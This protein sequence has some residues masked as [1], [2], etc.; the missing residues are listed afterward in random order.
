MRNRVANSIFGLA[1]LFVFVIIT[2]ASTSAAINPQ[3]NFQGKITNPDGT[4]IVNGSY[5]IR[6]RLYTDPALDAANTCSA[7]TCKW[8]ESK[9]ITITDGIFQTALGSLT[10]L[11]GSVDFNTS[12]IYLGIKVG[13]DPE[14]APRVQFTA[15][16][17][18]FNSDKVGGFTAAQLVQLTPAGQQSGSINVSG[19]ITTASTLAV[20][21]SNAVTLGSST[22]VGAILFQDGTVNN[23]TVT[24]NVAALPTASYSLTLPTSAPALSQCLQSGASVAGQLAFGACGTLQQNYAASG[25]PALITTTN[26]K[27]LQV[28]LANTATAANFLVNVATGSTGKFAIQNNSTDVFLYSVAT[29]LSTNNNSLAVGSG[30]VNAAI[31]NATTGLNTGAASGTQ[32][33]DSTGN[34]VSI[35]NITTSGATTLSTTGATGVTIKPGSETAS[36]FQLQSAAAINFIAFNSVTST[37][38]FGPTSANASTVTIATGAAAQAVTIGSTNTTSSTA[39]QGGTTGAINLGSVGSSTLASTTAIAST[40]D[41]TGLQSV[42]IGSNAN[43]NNTVSIEA[44]NTGLIKIGDASTTAHTIRI[45]ASGLAAGTAQTVLVGSNTTTTASIVKLQAGNVTSVNGQAGVTVGGGFSTSDTNLVPLNLDSTITLTE[46][47]NTCT[48]SVNDGALYF[49]ANA[50]SMAMRACINGGWE[51]LISTAGAFFAFFGVIP[52]SG[53]VPGDIQ[54]LSTA[55]STGPCKV[56]W[57]SA[58]TLNVQACAAYSGGRKVMVTATT[59]TPATLAA[60][61]FYHICLTGTN[62]QP[63]AS[64]GSTNESANLNTLSFPTGTGGPIVC[65]A[66]VKTSAVAITGI[67]DT[68]MYTTTT[69]EFGYSAAPLSLANMVK[70]DATNPNRLALPGITATGFM[71]GVVVATDGAAWVSGGPNVVIATAGTAAVKATGGTL[72]ASST[73]QNSTVTSG[74]AITVTTASA[75]AYGNLGIAQNTFSTTC[76]TTANCNGSLLIDLRLR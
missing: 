40:S 57:A 38:N 69:K 45:G 3:I 61:N 32:R 48:T 50:G 12:A 65:L 44:G 28:V 14:M 66:D 46:T 29:G 22:N 71:R 60:G 52:D 67:Y 43:V 74:Y 24:L 47:A 20:Q 25:A 53:T 63:V 70:P 2:T 49:N 4:N 75:N 26:A 23:R 17:Y 11:P 21:G 62:N 33:V 55:N 30:T 37:I 68:R 5:T 39:I 41:A 6:F 1:A 58:T 72:S 59:L 15:S 64:V 27:D 10:T 56:S 7:N 34:L 19:T 51:D 8:E 54:A 13:V 76:T 73:V 16:P 36:A 18:A 9:P 35:G 42:N 31:V